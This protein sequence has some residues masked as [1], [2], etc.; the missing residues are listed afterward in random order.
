[1]PISVWS[2]RVHKAQQRAKLAEAN[3]AKLE[4]ESSK[5]QRRLEKAVECDREGKTP[6]S[7][8]EAATGAG[9]F[10]VAE[11]QPLPLETATS[12]GQ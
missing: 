10:R 1:M 12:I 3:A 4:T 9:G 6:E 5:L 7:R 2:E 8:A 11:R